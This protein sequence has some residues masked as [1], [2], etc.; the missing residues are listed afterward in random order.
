[1]VHPS[2]QCRGKTTTTDIFKHVGS[3]GGNGHK[4]TQEILSAL[5]ERVFSGE[6]ECALAQ[7]AQRGCGVTILRGTQNSPGTVLEQLPL[8]KSA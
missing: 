8:D 2:G 4:E 1:M 7:V 5:M 6:G 3:I